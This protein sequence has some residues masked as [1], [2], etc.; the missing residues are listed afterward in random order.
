MWL[1]FLK[2]VSAENETKMISNGSADMIQKS[3]D[4][5]YDTIAVTEE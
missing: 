5:I 1:G 4:D 3:G 2:K